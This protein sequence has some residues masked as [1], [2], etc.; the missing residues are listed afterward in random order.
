MPANRIGQA[1][2]A[3]RPGRLHGREN[4]PAGRMQL[5]I[6]D[7]GRAQLELVDAVAGETGVRVAV[8][9]PRY[10]AETATVELLELPVGFSKCRIKPAHRAEGGDSPVLAEDVRVAHDLDCPERFAPKRRLAAGRSR[11]LGEVADEQA[12]PAR[13]VGHSAD[14]GCIGGSIPCPAAKAIAS[15]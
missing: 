2:F 3:R 11:E 8:D 5:L 10:G 12:P 13:P 9:Q 15:G 1:R 14:W 7:A 4:A 6:G